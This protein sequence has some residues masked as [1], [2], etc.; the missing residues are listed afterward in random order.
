MRRCAAAIARA[1]VAFLDAV[2][3]GCLLSCFRPRPRRGSGSSDALVHGDRAA[4]LTDGGGCDEEEE[5]RL[6]ANYLKLCGTISETPAEL[7]TEC[8][9]MPTAVAATNW[10][11]L[12]ETTSEGCEENHAPSELSIEDTQHLPGVELVPDAAF[13]GKSLFQNMQHKQADCSG[14]PFATPLV[15]RDDMQTPGTIYTSQRGASMS[16]K[17]VHIRKQFVYPV[18]RP[19]E[20]RL[21]QMEVTEDS[22]PSPPSNP[23]K[24]KNLEV[25]SVKKPKQAYSTSVVKSGLSETSSSF[26]RQV[27]EALSPEELLDSGELSNTKSGEKNA[28]FSLCHWVKSSSTTD[29]K[30]QGNVKG[31]A[32][33]QSYDECSF[34]TERPGFNAS[35]LGWDIEN[36][37][38]GLPKTWDGNGIPNTITRYKEDQRVSWHTTP[39]EERLLKVLS[40]EEHRPPRK[41]VRGKL[42]H[43]EKKAE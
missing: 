2:L 20:N 22:S 6:E 33:D 3:V 27:K 40:D 31:A 15:L 25:D 24:R 13:L 1:V 4:E 19:I 12:F 32:G 38:P 14:S 8:D 28:A 41:V 17:R 36:P 21:Q 34:P 7:Q 37:T 43:L 39:F 11:S 30:N 29:V 5:L 18:L 42:F 16:G 35:D 23:P 10:A 26:S 9:N